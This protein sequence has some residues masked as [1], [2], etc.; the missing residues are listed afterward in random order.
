MWEWQQLARD[1]GQNEE[2]I[3]AQET[4]VQGLGDPTEEELE[5][6]DRGRDHRG[7]DPGR[8]KPGQST[9]SP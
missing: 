4:A 5:G 6:S 9:R 1:E 3:A 7:A 2:D 8:K